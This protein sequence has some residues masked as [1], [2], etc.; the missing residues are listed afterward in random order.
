MARHMR[1]FVLFLLPALGGCASLPTG[2]TV[3]ALPGDGKSF[4]QF[5]NDDAVCRQWA[6]RRIGLPQEQVAG[7]NTATGAVAGT[8]IGAGLGAALGAAGGDVGAGVAFG[9]VSGLLIGGS[10]GAQA[11]QAY[12][13][14]AQRRYDIAYE[15]CMYAKGNR[16]PGVERRSRRIYSAPPPSPGYYYSAPPYYAP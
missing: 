16:I 9:A 12:G 3:L 2:P 5:I 7:R 10:A 4:D 6:G 14:E 1:L 15:Q 11:D 13:W 8:A